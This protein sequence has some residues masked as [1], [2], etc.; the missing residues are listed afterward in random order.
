[1]NNIN[2]NIQAEGNEVILKIKVEEVQSTSK[3][4]EFEPIDEK[5]ISWLENWRD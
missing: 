4:C 5:E 1:M 3:Y 2:L